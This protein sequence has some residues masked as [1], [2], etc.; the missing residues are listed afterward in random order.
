MKKKT[1]LSSAAL[2]AIVLA[3]IVISLLNHDGIRPENGSGPTTDSGTEAPAPAD[4]ASTVRIDENIPTAPSEYRRPDG[5]KHRGFKWDIPT[6]SSRE[7]ARQ[8]RRAAKLMARVDKV[9]AE[10]R[11]HGTS[12]S[13][14]SHQC[15]EWFIDAKLGIFID[16][17]PWSLASYCP[18]VKGA[19]LYP[20]W[21]ERRCRPGTRD[22]D[23]H[24]LNWG[25]DFV[26]DDFIDL[27]QGKRFNAEAL[28]EVF[29]AGGARYVVPFLKHHG[30]FCLWDSSWTF[31]DSHDR[32]AKR[33]FAK[34]LSTACKAHD[35]KFG[36]YNSMQGEWEYPVLC[37]DGSIKMFT[38]NT[39]F[40]DYNPDFEKVASGKVAVRDVFRECMVPQTIE[41]IDKYDPDI[42][43]Y[44]FDWTIPATKCG[45]YD[46]AAYFY[47]KNEG[48]KEVAVNDRYGLLEDNEDGERVRKVRSVGRNWSRTVHGDFFTDEW[49]DTDDCLDPSS[50]HPWE[51][52][53]GISKSYGN[54]WMEQFDPSMV[55]TDKEFIIHFMDIVSRGGNLLLL[56][57]LDGQG[58]LP[59]IQRERIQSIG[60]WLSRWGEG[61]YSTRIV[62]PFSTPDVDYT[63]SKDGK[64]VF[65]TVKECA[66]VEVTLECDI[67]EGA[68]ITVL[69]ENTALPYH[70]LD[71]DRSKTVVQVPSG[72]ADAALP[73]ILAVK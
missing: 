3:G 16:W 69:G 7:S 13:I 47:N 12:E 67:P 54:H 5:W 30:G 33:D 46:V 24:V 6:I 53:S 25:E 40:V 63:I 51:S 34:E 23:Y 35:M 10:G 65:A 48:R 20:D 45:A 68:T 60:K 27:F 14:D 11:Y 21:Y 29:E 26:S 52:C 62:E 73:F 32:G 9:N 36:F 49:G 71:S 42:I 58:A 72:Y 59:D 66:S 64:T 61:V 2:C 55:M 57:N 4:K 41:F 38:E 8:I 31:R 18:Y 56:V 15:P 28:I 44:D 43:W 50:W 17:G 39:D 22:Y 19:N 70:R 1:L 37:E